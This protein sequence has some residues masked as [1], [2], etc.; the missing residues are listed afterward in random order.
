MP[1]FQYASTVVPAFTTMVEFS[2]AELW[3]TDDAASVV[4]VGTPAAVVKL[5]V[6]EV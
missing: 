4:T 3:A 6:D 2:V 1:Y 5:V